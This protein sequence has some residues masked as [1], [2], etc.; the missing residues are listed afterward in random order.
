VTAL[1]A[2]TER[3]VLGTVRDGDL[4]FAIGGPIAFFVCFNI[5]LRKVI[6]TGGMSY[7]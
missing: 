3:S 7:P 4:L 6:D 5:T 1:A 2:L